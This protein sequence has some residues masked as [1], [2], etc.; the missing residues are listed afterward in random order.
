MDWS[1]SKT[2]SGVKES[3]LLAGGSV[4]AEEKELLIVRCRRSFE[5]TSDLA[6][7]RVRGHHHQPLEEHSE[8]ATG[9]KAAD[10][11]SDRHHHGH[12]TQ[13]GRRSLP[14]RDMM[15]TNAHSVS[16]IAVSSPTGT[17][18]GLVGSGGGGGARGRGAEGPGGRRS[19]WHDQTQHAESAGQRALLRVAP[20]P[21]RLVPAPSAQR[22]ARPS[23][24][25]CCR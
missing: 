24:L 2:A 9:R 22:T 10:S 25:G 19:P 20:K 13:Q 16:R 12:R 21:G 15:S 5:D 1:S 14:R 7:C 8:A 6:G 23:L 17:R 3:D 4:E 18:P 11:N